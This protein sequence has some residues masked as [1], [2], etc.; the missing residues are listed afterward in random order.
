MR[1]RETV[2]QFYEEPAESEESSEE[3][4]EQCVNCQQIREP[5]SLFNVSP[6]PAERLQAPVYSPRFSTA[7]NPRKANFVEYIPEEDE[8]DLLH[9]LKGISHK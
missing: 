3:I 7:A 5:Q 6:Q 2:T 8:L 1:N 4:Y 9:Q